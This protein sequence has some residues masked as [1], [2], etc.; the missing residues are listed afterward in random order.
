[1]TTKRTMTLNLTA[2]EMVVL[3]R[4][5]SEKGLTKTG[6]VRQSLRLYQSVTERLERGEKL[7]VEDSDKNEKAELLVL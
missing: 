3:D 5:A 1:M 6:L 7:F 4:L 2:Q